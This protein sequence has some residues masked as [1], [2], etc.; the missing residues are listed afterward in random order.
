MD[1]SA[2]AGFM[3]AVAECGPI[4]YSLYPFPQTRRGAW[5]VLGAPIRPAVGGPRCT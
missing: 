1:A 3:R 5:R 4:G 2:T